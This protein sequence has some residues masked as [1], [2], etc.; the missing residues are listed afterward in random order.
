MV[1]KLAVIFFTCFTAFAG[2][3]QQRI[4]Q[5]INSNW[6]FYKGALKLSQLTDTSLNW[7]TVNVPHSWNT[8]DVMDDTPGYYRGETWYKKTVFIS[9]SWK[10]KTVSLYFEGANQTTEVYVNGRKVGDHIGGYTA[11]SFVLNA[12]LQFDHP[13]KGNEIWVKVDNSYNDN[14]P[15]LTADFTFFGGIYRDVY[16]IAANPVHFDMG[17]LASDGVFI[18]TPMVSAQSANVKLNGVIENAGNETKDVEVISTLYDGNGKKLSEKITGYKPK[19]NQ[20]T[21][22]EQTLPAITNPILWSPDNPY[23][24]KLVSVIS[25]KKTKEQLDLFSTAV[26]FRWFKFTADEGFFI[27]GKHLKLV[28][29]N[30]HQDYKDMANALPDALHDRDMQ[31]LKEMGGNFVRIAHYPQDPAVLEACDRLGIL[32]WVET[33]EVNRITET[34]AFAENSLHMQ[35]E[36]IRQNYNHP[37][38]IIWAFMNEVLLRPRYDEKTKERAT[39]IKEVAALAQR[40]EDLTR[41]EDPTR[42]TSIAFHGNF[43]AYYDSGLTNIP[44]IIGWNL[45]SGWYGGKFKDLEGFLAKSHKILPDKPIIITEFGADADRRLHA[46]EPIKFD[47]SMEYAMEYHKHYLH[48]IDSLPYL[49]GAA[50]WNLVEFNSEGRAESWPHINYKGIMSWDRKAKPA[51]FLYQADLLKK[52][53]VAIASKNWTVRSGVLANDADSVYME[54]VEVFSNQREITMVVNGK[55]LGSKRTKNTSAIFSVPFRDGRNDLQAFATNN[56]QVEDLAEVDFT[57]QSPDLKSKKH[58][59]KSIRVSLGDQREFTDELLHQSWLPEQPYFKGGWGY[60]GGEVFKEKGLLPY[61][62]GKLIKGTLNDPIYQ[63]QRVGL[64]AFVLDV[65]D[66]EYEVSLHFAEFLSGQQQKTLAYNLGGEVSQKEEKAS[67]DFDVNINGNP[68]LQDFGNNNYLVPEQAIQ[69]KTTITVLNGEGLH[70]NFMAKS[71]QAILNAIEVK[72]IF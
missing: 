16:L 71:G 4:K 39:Y 56:H 21:S 11:F 70:I 40:L 34:E 37:S 72:K 7:R 25:D 28:G 3:S 22:F 63:T 41:K 6:S 8:E 67:R 9:P 61:G 66:G 48:A 10:N 20:K 18:T 49:A 57:I 47:K 65:P 12:Y 68:F 17:N 60:V 35:R 2:Y 43:D 51:Y 15:P 62:T 1:K 5:S 46:K 55:S 44:M 36:M 45:Y 64:D 13:E 23:L 31:L 54:N 59:F 32:A 52:P 19:S 14:I 38:V 42:Y 69:K 26:G 53:M 30:R 27:N 24:Y 58:P 29:A 33:P 50:I